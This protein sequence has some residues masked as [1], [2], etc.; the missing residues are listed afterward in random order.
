[1]GEKAPAKDCSREKALVKETLIHK[2]SNFEG[3]CLLSGR[4]I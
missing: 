4:V 2:S 3:F 1:M